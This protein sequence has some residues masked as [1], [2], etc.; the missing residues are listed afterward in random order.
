MKALMPLV[1]EELVKAGVDF[2]K[3]HVGRKE[4]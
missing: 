1:A 2:S 3:A 4:I